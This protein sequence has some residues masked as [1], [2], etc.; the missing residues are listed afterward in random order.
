[1]TIT[2]DAARSDLDRVRGWL[3]DELHHAYKYQ[4]SVTVNDVI[5]PA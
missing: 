3:G 4:G 1:M 2:I 5:I